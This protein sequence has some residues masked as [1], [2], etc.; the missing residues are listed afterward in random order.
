MLFYT[1][2]AQVK[3]AMFWF[4]VCTIQGNRPTNGL[5]SCLCILNLNICIFLNETHSSSKE[6]IENI[7]DVII[8]RDICLFLLCVHYITIVMT[9]ASLSQGNL[10]AH[11]KSICFGWSIM[12][13]R[14]KCVNER[15]SA[16]IVS[17]CRNEYDNTSFIFVIYA[18]VH[19]FSCKTELINNVDRVLPFN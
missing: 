18:A 14:N 13:Y 9:V 1:Y 16:D 19:S 10:L 2:G 15:C 3:R 11:E 6:A 8:S 5:L 12:R 7:S 4:C 17:D